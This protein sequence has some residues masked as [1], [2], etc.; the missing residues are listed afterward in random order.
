MTVP[1]GTWQGVS[2]D[3]SYLQLPKSTP[4]PISTLPEV[5]PDHA[6]AVSIKSPHLSCAYQPSQ[7]TSTTLPSPPRTP[8]LAAQ[9]PPLDEVRSVRTES[10]GLRSRFLTVWPVLIPRARGQLRIKFREC[11]Y[12]TPDP[13]RAHCIFCSL[14]RSA[15]TTPSRTQS[16]PPHLRRGWR[17]KSS[18]LSPMCPR[19]SLSLHDAL[20]VKSV[21]RACTTG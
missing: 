17:R 2:Q 16:G 21:S 1:S 13:S 15:W 10:P 14:I 11:C 12:C 5:Q 19:Q 8:H 4:A 6:P 9:D 3:V 18:Q 7:C 20:Q